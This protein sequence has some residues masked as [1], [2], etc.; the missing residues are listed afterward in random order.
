MRE[1]GLVTIFSDRNFPRQNICDTT[2]MLLDQA[3]LKRKDKFLKELVWM[4]KVC[5]TD[6]RSLSREIVSPDGN[7]RQYGKD[8]HNDVSAV[9]DRD[10]L[11]HGEIDYLAALTGPD[12]TTLTWW[13]C[14]GS[15]TCPGCGNVG[16]RRAL[17]QGE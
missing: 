4:A 2:G 11:S 8:R 13:C 16:T 9:W 15:H 7:G 3:Y 1:S 17:P 5:A 14:G 12:A 6:E 10:R